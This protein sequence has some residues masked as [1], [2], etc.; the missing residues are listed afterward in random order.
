V[1]WRA[2]SGFRHAARTSA[3]DV[4]RY[5]QDELGNALG[6]TAALILELENYS[7]AS[8]VWVTLQRHDAARYGKPERVKIDGQAYVIAEDGEGGFLILFCELPASFETEGQTMSKPADDIK[9]DA[10]IQAEAAAKHEQERELAASKGEA[11]PGDP[12]TAPAQTMEPEDEK[13]KGGAGAEADP[14]ITPLMS[15]LSLNIRPDI[16]TGPGGDHIVTTMKNSTVDRDAVDALADMAKANADRAGDT[17]EPAQTPGERSEGQQFDIDT[18]A[19]IGDRLKG[20]PA[21]LANDPATRL[22]LAF[23][24]H[25]EKTQ[26]LDG[27]P[28]EHWD[29]GGFFDDTRAAFYAA[30]AENTPQEPAQTPG[31]RD[32]SPEAIIDRQNAE[33]TKAQACRQHRRGRA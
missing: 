29:A 9:A 12:A 23:E 33:S 20:F 8:L 5:E 31:E 25:V 10:E 15:E 11:L 32:A 2:D 27:L 26:N 28:F 22:E 13:K 6:I 1:V 3:A 19:Y 14:G 30:H 21:E 18:E 24:A 16:A 17:Q 4:I 7:A